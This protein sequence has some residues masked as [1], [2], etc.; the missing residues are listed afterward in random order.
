MVKIPVAAVFSL[1]MCICPD[2][3]NMANSAFLLSGHSY[4]VKRALCVYFL[5]YW[6]GCAFAFRWPL[7]P[8]FFHASRIVLCYLLPC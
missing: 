4:T 3:V 8:S 6:A 1:V 5:I 2:L 7:Q